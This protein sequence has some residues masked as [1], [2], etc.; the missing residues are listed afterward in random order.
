[1]KTSPKT[2]GYK[3]HAQGLA[4][5]LDTGLEELQPLDHQTDSRTTAF[6]VYQH[7]RGLTVCVKSKIS[8]KESTRICKDEKHK[9]GIEAKQAGRIE[10][11]RE[12]K[13]D[14]QESRF[15]EITQKTGQG[16]K[17]KENLGSKKYG[18][19]GNT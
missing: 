14:D 17:K 16:D 2:Q 7:M 4:G 19:G 5:A 12:K 18:R 9:L 8:G 11:D 15:E 6:T 13:T 3:A 10:I 1:M